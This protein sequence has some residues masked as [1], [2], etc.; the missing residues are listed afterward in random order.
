MHRL[1]T[2]LGLLQ[3]LMNLCLGKDEVTVAASLHLILQ[4]KS[5]ITPKFREEGID[6]LPFLNFQ[7]H[8]TI[9]IYNFFMFPSSWIGMANLAQA[10]RHIFVDA[11]FN[12]QA[13]PEFQ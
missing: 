5:K 10:F 12:F 8:F 13:G 6:K 2:S 11:Y 4:V 9:E 3:T 7:I 1:D